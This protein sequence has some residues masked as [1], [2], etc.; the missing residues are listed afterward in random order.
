[1]RLMNIRAYPV[2]QVGLGE[3]VGAQGDLARICPQD[4]KPR[5]MTDVTVAPHADSNWIIIM[6]VVFQRAGKY[7][8]GWA[9]IGYVS[10]GHRGWQ[11][12]YVGDIRITALSRSKNPELVG[13][14]TC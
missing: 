9:R 10:G 12:Y 13:P 3:I 6:E 1:M 7:R 8:F 4:Y 14:E 11:D 5:Q 2:K